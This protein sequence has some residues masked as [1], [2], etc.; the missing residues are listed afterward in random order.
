M[1]IE[2]STVSFWS[3]SPAQLAAQIASV[4]NGDTPASDEATRA[5]ASL[6]AAEWQQARDLPNATFED[7]ETRVAQLDSLQKRIIEVLIGAGPRP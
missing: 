2:E 7:Q 6:L 3:L 5:E 4:A 1:A